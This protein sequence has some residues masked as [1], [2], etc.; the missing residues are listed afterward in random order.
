MYNADRQTEEYVVG[1]HSFLEVARA[2]K[3]AKGFMCCPCS[4]CRNER[5]YYDW[6]TL[7]HHLIK[8]DFMPNYVVWTKHGERWVVMED[9]EE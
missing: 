9:D 7:H 4:H 1:M 2:N 8:Y 5:D 3:S 6:G